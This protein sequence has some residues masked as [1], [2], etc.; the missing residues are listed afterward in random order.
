MSTT[1][2]PND[3]QRSND[4]LRRLGV[5]Y[6]HVIQIIFSA[7]YKFMSF[8]K[9]FS[10]LFSTPRKPADHGYWITAKCNRCG[11]IIRAR[12]DLHNDLSINYG[13]KDEDTTYFCRKMLIGSQHCYQQIE[14]EL[15]FDA[16]R[17]LIRK[18]IHGGKFVEEDEA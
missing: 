5:K 14:I 18:E 3:P 9:R 6:H 12:V 16:S 10:Y 13:D 7:K 17:R 8:L 2:N 11:E 1:A 4:Y 15:N